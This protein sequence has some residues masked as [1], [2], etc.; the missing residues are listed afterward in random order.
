MNNITERISF[1]VE[2]EFNGNKSAF[3]RAI[4]VTPAYVSKLCLDSSATPSDRTISDICLVLKINERWLRTGNGEMKKQL[5]EDEEL[6]SLFSKLMHEDDSETLI[7]AKR[8]FIAE[9]LKLEPA[10]WEKILEIAK[11]LA[12][13]EQKNTGQE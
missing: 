3:A 11:V 5:S 7:K 6:T 2:S 12:E 9:M 8:A 1:L 13:N 10:A 4:G